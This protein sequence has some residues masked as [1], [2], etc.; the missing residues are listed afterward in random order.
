MSKICLLLN[1]FFKM[2]SVFS[3][4][5][6]N[7]FN[8]ESMTDLE[9]IQKLK[10]DDKKILAIQ[11]QGGEE[12]LVTSDGKLFPT[13]LLETLEEEAQQKKEIRDA[14]SREEQLKESRELNELYELM[15]DSSVDLEWD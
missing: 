4:R 3:D 9:L 13:R 12:C 5:E 14:I 1:I 10:E 6:V 11:S 15:K 2:F 8:K 7:E